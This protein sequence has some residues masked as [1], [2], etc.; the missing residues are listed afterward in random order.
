MGKKNTKQGRC[1]EGFNAEPIAFAFCIL[2]FA[3][4]F[5]AKN[6]KNFRF[7]FRQNFG[8]GEKFMFRRTFGVWEEILRLGENFGF[9]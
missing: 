2:H 9:R 8:L 1:N 6:S 5:P 3:L 4:I 7:W